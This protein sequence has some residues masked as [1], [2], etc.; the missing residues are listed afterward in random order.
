M[1]QFIWSVF[2]VANLASDF[3]GHVLE[4]PSTGM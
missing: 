4:V 2:N 3:P 1:M